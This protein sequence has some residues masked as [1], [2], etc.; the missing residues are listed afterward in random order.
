MKKLLFVS[1][2]FFLSFGSAVSQCV[3][4]YNCWIKHYNGT[5]NNADR[6]NDIEVSSIS[7]NA[8]ATGETRNAFGAHSDFVT[9][10]YNPEGDTLWSRVY[11]GTGDGPD[12]AY[13]IAIDNQENVYVTGESK[14]TGSTGQD[15]V[16]IKY[17]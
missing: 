4:V 10:K 9:I 7:G 15:F 2:I 13:S 5:A 3:N 14:G 16:T 12:I 11:N 1:A 17:N 6:L 8:F